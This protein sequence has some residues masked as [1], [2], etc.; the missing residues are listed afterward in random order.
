MTTIFS[1]ESVAMGHPDK[2]ADQ[3]SDA[4]LDAYLSQDPKAKV[5]CETMITP[6]HVLLAG[7]ITSS[8]RVDHKS[9]VLSVLRSDTFQVS[10]FFSTQSPDIAQAVNK[11]KIG[12]GDQGLMIGYATDETE[13]FMPLPFVLANSLIEL[14]RKKRE[15][16]E[17]PFLGADGKALVEVAYDGLTPKTI[18]TIILSIQHTDKI[19]T[20]SLRDEI[21]KILPLCI[22][23]HLI[24][25]ATRT[26]INPSGRFVIGGPDADVG[27]TG[28]KQMVDTY[29]SIVRH[30]GG[31]FSGKDPTKVD[32]SAAYLAR[33]IAK[34]IVA[35][36]LASRC[37]VSLTY[38]IG[39]PDPITL[40]VNTF[41][42]SSFSNEKLIKAI[43]EIFALDVA[44]MIK[45]LDLER[46]IY[47]KTAYGGHFGRPEFTWEQTDKVDKLA[48]LSN[49]ELT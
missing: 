47:Q 20:A 21:Q 11:S 15:S 2:L 34:N 8:A 28:R 40:Q 49:E 22:P 39:M 30:G 4:I 7:E 10:E 38:A 44:G 14:L 18:Q 48:K 26:L 16:K 45:M 31:A 25:H 13:S 5:A 6:G 12:A 33:Y 29:G 46:P 37:E 17:M 1:A 35:A 42:T 27:M 32:R 19:S 24:T 41:N 9:C 3:I 36:K 23:Q 43:L